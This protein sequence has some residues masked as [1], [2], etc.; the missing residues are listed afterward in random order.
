MI[1]VL[2]HEGEAQ[3]RG[4]LSFNNPDVAMVDLFYTIVTIRSAN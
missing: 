3:G 4:Q 2:I 1:I